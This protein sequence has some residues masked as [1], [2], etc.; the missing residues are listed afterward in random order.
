MNSDSTEHPT[1]P[2]SRSLQETVLLIEDNEALCRLL[3]DFIQHAGYTLMEG[4]ADDLQDLGRLFL[5]VTSEHVD[6]ILVSLHMQSSHDGQ[7][8]SA[9]RRRFPDLPMIVLIAHTDQVGEILRGEEGENYSVGVTDFFAKPYRPR[10]IVDRIHTLLQARMP[11][12]GEL[13][14]VQ[15]WIW[16]DASKLEV[17][18]RI[19]EDHFEEV[20]TLS[21]I[22]FKL[23]QHFVNHPYRI[24][25]REYLIRLVYADQHHMEVGVID[26]HISNLGSKLSKVHPKGSMFSL[27]GGIGYRFEQP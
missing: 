17:R 2:S 11:A 4:R 18:I 24:F 1:S 8:F 9:L 22:E 6:L 25:T 26:R 21:P 16:F 19:E 20:I 15:N 23:L 13:I 10:A 3:S 27:M 5:L 7:V 14:S 12:M